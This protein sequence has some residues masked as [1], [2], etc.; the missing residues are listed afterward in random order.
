[1]R[2]TVSKRRQSPAVI[3]VAL[4]DVLVVLVIFLVV[5]TTFKQQPD[6]KLALPKSSQARRAGATENPPV[7][8]FIDATGSLRVG[9]DAKPVT[10]DRLREEL[11]QLTATRT[12]VS[13]TLD[14]DEKAPWGQIIRV[15]DIAKELN[16]Q[17]VSAS[18]KE[19]KK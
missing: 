3:I 10:A 11:R 8:V 1:M 12:N 7:M 6:M 13:I 19:I 18:T 2:F 14:A 5:T 15:W 9:K 16:I 17:A 4:I